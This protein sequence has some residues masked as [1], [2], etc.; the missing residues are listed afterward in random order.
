MTELEKV[1]LELEE[2]ASSYAAPADTPGYENVWLPPDNT[3]RM[4]SVPRSTGELLY[5]FVSEHKPKTILEL[6]TS[7]GYSTLWLASAAREYGGHVYTIEMAKP[8]IEMAQSY[9]DRVGFSSDIT[10][11]EGMV[12]E[13]LQSWNKPVDL[14]FMDADKHNYLTY[15]KAIEPYLSTGATVIADNAVDFAHLMPDFLEYMTMSEKYD[16]ELLEID[17]GLLVAEKER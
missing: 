12:S 2:L 15:I 1:F 16:S 4:W 13:V 8:K 3:V 6:G 17:N 14:L 5:K 9:I 11:L 7:S 10:I